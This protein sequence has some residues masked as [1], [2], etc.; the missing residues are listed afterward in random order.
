MVRDHHRSARNLNRRR[1]LQGMG[2]AGVVGVAGCLG[3]NG[4]GNGDNES[5]GGPDVGDGEEVDFGDLQEGGTLRA[6]VG[7][8]VSSFDPPYS[9]DTTATQAQN[10]I[11]EQLITS[12][13]AG[14]YYPWLA[15][16]YELVETQ[17]ID[18][19]AYADYMTAVS[20]NEDG[21]L[22]T[23]AQVLLQ[24]PDDDPVES[25]EVRVITPEEASAAVDDG[26]FGMQ[27]RYRL[28]EGV[29]FH[30]GEELTAENVVL[31]V[32]R[33][34]N[35]DVSAQT[36]DSLLHA[37]EVDEYTVDLFAQVP[38]AEA[39]GQLPGIYVFTTEQ[40]G[41]EDG[42][43]DPRQGNEPIGTGP[44]QFEDFADEQYYELSKFRD[45]WV[46]DLGIAEKEWFDGPEGYPDGPVI[47]TIEAE[48]VPDPASR[49]AALRNGEI[50]VTTGLTTD[51]LDDFDSSEEFLVAGIEAG[52]Y[53]YIQYPVNIE[54][55][56][57]QRLRTA[58]NHLVPR[59]SIV[60]NVLNGWARPA[61]TPIPEL[62]EESGTTDPEALEEELRPANEYD[63]ERA[64]EILD[65][66][67]DDLGIEYPL[68][69]T[70][71]TNADND[72]R[73]QMV[74]LI[75]ESMGQ[76]DYFETS[77]ETYEWNTYTTRVLDPEYPEEELIPCI[78]LSG[79]F[80]PESY[81]DALHGSANIGQ[82]CNMT[83]ISD[84]EF[85][86]LVDAA[87]FDPE[88]V[89]DEQLRAER[90]DEIWQLLA[91]RRYSSITHFD[92][93]A[94]VSNT[95]VTGF[96]MYPFDEGVYSF[97]LYNPTEAQAMWLDREE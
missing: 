46:E 44:Y 40:A 93:E 6:A 50:D 62:A 71:E 64:G 86:D 10:F 58:V 11:F 37:R 65:E 77:V 13:R 14:T 2:T 24:H 78:G 16:S 39:E 27:Y 32:E 23:D 49:A 18:R 90:Y 56:D 55:W 7:A 28:H 26:V 94:A 92:I 35:S 73:V 48:I 57:D 43:I 52:G 97:A 61:W 22:E 83:G 95:A 69:V 87:R 89:E 9:T 1:L 5:D 68:Q 25:D 74:E 33:Y 63:P 84:Q 30:N 70:L 81:C 29:Q 66:V 72:D 53:E 15:E 19:T 42:A 75:A 59:E 3:G 85:D 60:Q 45:Y 47:D 8:N 51:T 41:L 91:D 21:V 34:E 20:A 36:F 17:D 80:N 76:T 12:D 54:P 38:D 67:G 31:S 79:T 88:V 96:R 4:D 82:C